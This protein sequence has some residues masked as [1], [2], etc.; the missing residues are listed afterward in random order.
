M[1]RKVGQIA[2]LGERTW[3][4]RVFLGRDPETRKRKYENRTIHGALKQAQAYLNKRLSERDLG[5]QGDGAKIPLNQYLDRWLSIV[6]TRV[7]E[8][9]C[10][11]YERLL[12]KYVRPQLGERLL[13][14]ISPLDIQSAYQLITDHGLSA[15]TVRYTHSVLGSALRQAVKWRLLL[16]N[17]VEGVQ[18]PRLVRREMQVLTAEQARAF[19][20]A[21]L[22]TTY[23]PVLAVA[24]TTGMRPSEYLG[25]KWQDIDWE[26]GT[27]SVT[28]TLKKGSAGWHFAD[29]KRT[30][31]RRVVKLQ[32][33]ILGLLKELRAA[34]R[35]FNVESDEWPEAAD[36]V[37]TTPS[38]RPISQ[39]SLVYKH[40]KPI[41]KIAC[42]P[43]TPRVSGALSRRVRCYNP[44]S[45]FSGSSP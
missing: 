27:V 25:L 9:T 7:R 8:K 44:L 45:A 30:R 33:W 20:K 34:R 32:N 38:G 29:T 11:D 24:L 18:L 16:Q 17:P 4:V 43:N 2:A 41:L 39:N 28:R 1:A 15:R 40:F 6:K 12:E 26:R 19:L 14:G 23:G 3:M 36:L 35:Q 21:A 5:R 22:P 42:L 13:T 37:F 10:Q 31:S